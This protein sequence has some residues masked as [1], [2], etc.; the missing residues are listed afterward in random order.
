MTI[1]TA[2][3]SWKGEV[4]LWGHAMYDSSAITTQS[5]PKIL[6]AACKILVAV[7]KL[8]VAACGS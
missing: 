7:G 1:F 4:V 2:L 8:L 6:F 3:T 5:P